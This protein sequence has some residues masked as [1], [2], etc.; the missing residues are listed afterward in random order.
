[1]DGMTPLKRHGF[2]PFTRDIYEE[3]LTAAWEHEFNPHRFSQSPHLLPAETT[4]SS[5]HGLPEM[6]GRIR[7][8]F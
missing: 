7:T 5:G 3:L 6:E 2:R 4:F 1:M 8:A